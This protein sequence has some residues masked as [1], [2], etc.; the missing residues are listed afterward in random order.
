M[1]TTTNFIALSLV[2]CGLALATGCG[3]A[4]VKH[5]PKVAAISGAKMSDLHGTAPIE[6]KNASTDSS[7]R[8]I[9]VAGVG[10]IMGN[11]SEWSAAAVKGVEDNLRSRGATIT[12]GAPKSI[13]IAVAKAEAHGVPLAG[14][15]KSSVTITV[16]T[17]DGS[18]AS[19]EGSGA[20]L[21]PLG[22]VDGAMND[23][24]KKLLRD[25]SLESYLRR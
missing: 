22:A 17:G 21:A 1:K 16:A 11:L 25:P 24:V 18:Q 14:V 12:A 20:S 23:A 8:K 13:A 10:R 15:T 9:G 6:I 3:V 5:T 19:F 4:P 2:T 7:E